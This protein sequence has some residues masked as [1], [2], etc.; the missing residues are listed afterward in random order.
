MS[1]STKKTAKKTATKSAALP[2]KRRQPNGKGALYSAGVPGNRGGSGRPPSELRAAARME[3]DVRIPLL[4]KF[5]GSS[6]EKT[7]D[8]IRAIEAL[9]RIGLEES[10]GVAD[11]RRA[12]DAT[13]ELIRDRLLHEVAD[14]LI[15]DIRAIWLRI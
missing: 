2:A 1:G 4:G 9:A 15:E 10:I 6:K 14:K 7:S 13:G 3:L 5:A 12:L 11:V 8:R